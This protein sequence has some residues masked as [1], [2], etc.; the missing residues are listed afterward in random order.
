MNLDGLFSARFFAGWG[1]ALGRELPHDAEDDPP[2]ALR[3]A[4]RLSDYL[5]P[6]L[7]AQILQ[8]LRVQRVWLLAVQD[9]LVLLHADVPP[10]ILRVPAADGSYLPQ[11]DPPLR[12]TNPAPRQL[13]VLPLRL[14]P[15]E[16]A[17]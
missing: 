7:V 3:Q 6:R 8:E 16:E 9:P 17:A 5:A 1:T 13:G 12:C 2:L 4:Q 11:R 14:R 10:A 15:R